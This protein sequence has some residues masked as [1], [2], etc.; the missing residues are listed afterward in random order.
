MTVLWH[1]PEVTQRLWDRK[2]CNYWKSTHRPYLLSA[3]AGKQWPQSRIAKLKGPKIRPSEKM[4]CL[5]NTNVG[6]LTHRHSC[7]VTVDQ[8]RMPT[9]PEHVTSLAY[10]TD[11]NQR[12]LWVTRGIGATRIHT[13]KSPPDGK[14]TW[15]RRLPDHIAEETVTWYVDA[16]LIDSDV[17]GASRFGA[18]A[19]AVDDRGHLLAAPSGVPPEY[20]S[21][22][23][24][25]DAWAAWIVLANTTTRKDLITDCKS[26]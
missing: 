18:A 9:P 1:H 16:S 23:V 17:P 7:P 22:I 13:S 19:A 14:V 4:Y 25:A 15:H 26:N 21:T 24:Q 12:D 5:C 2:Q 3:M 11:I 10:Y 6:T 20:V 8:R